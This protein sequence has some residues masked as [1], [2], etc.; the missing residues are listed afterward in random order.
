[1][2]FCKNSYMFK[3]LVIKPP[4]KPNIILLL[5]IRTVYKG[6]K[7]AHHHVIFRNILK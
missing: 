1:M 7:R 2:N 6:C 5:I 3:Q 4:F